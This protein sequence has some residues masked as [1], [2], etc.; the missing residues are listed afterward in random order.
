ME[1]EFYHTFKN[2]QKSRINPSLG[3][4]HIDSA[5]NYG[6]EEEVLLYTWQRW[7]KSNLLFLSFLPGWTGDQASNNGG[8]MQEVRNI[9]KN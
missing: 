4:R 2:I 8:I 7:E 6:N 3:Y 1:D 5:A 9:S